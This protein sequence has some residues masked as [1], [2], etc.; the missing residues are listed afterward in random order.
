MENESMCWPVA[1]P[2]CT[3]MRQIGSLTSVCVVPVLHTT[4]VVRGGVHQVGAVGCHPW[5][6]LP[7]CECSFLCFPSRPFPTADKPYTY[8]PSLVL[9][10]TQH[11]PGRTRHATHVQPHAHE[12]PPMPMP[13]PMPHRTFVTSCPTCM[14]RR[15]PT[16]LSTPAAKWRQPL[17]RP[18]SSSS[19]PL[20]PSPWPLAA[21]PRCEALGCCCA[22]CGGVHEAVVARNSSGASCHGEPR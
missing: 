6:P 7:T 11:P 9:Y 14:T 4:Q 2:A 20:T 17:V 1:S 12:H 8:S 10:E 18:W 13:M 5:R 21:S 15:P 3:E 19:C 22:E 16:P